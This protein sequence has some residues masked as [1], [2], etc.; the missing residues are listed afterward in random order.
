MNPSFAEVI[1]YN[2]GIYDGEVANHV[3]HGQGSYHRP[4]G[5]KYIGQWKDGKMHGLGVLNFSDGA[6]YVGQFKNDSFHGDGKITLFNGSFFLGE[7]RSDKPWS[8]SG[9]S[10]SGDANL[11]FQEGIPVESE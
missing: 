2:D 11:T 5:F 8:G 6:Q 9:Y 10:V 1:R 7:W 4:D 3:P